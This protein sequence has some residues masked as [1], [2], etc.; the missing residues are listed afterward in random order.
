MGEEENLGPG[1]ACIRSG[2]EFYA[3]D[4]NSIGKL[5]FYCFCGNIRVYPKNPHLFCIYFK[6]YSL[7][8]LTLLHFRA[9]TQTTPCI[10][11]KGLI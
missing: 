2:G 10:Q 8:D 3:A 6:L 11:P 9:S 7:Q 4:P 5:N 1:V